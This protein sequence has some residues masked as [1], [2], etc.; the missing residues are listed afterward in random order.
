[1]VKVE[2]PRASWDMVV[3]LIQDHPA[4]RDGTVMALHDEILN[5]VYSQEY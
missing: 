2:L 5:Q 4:F 3:A 1:M